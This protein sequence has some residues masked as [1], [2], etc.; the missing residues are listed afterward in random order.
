MFPGGKVPHHTELKKEGGF[1]HML[2]PFEVGGSHG[3]VGVPPRVD[4][5][6][7]FA[8]WRDFVVEDSTFGVAT[9]TKKRRRQLEGEGGINPDTNNKE[10]AITGEMY[11]FGYRNGTHPNGMKNQTL[12]IQFQNFNLDEI[13]ACSTGPCTVELNDNTNNC[14]DSNSDT[15][16]TRV[17]LH[18]DIANAVSEIG[19]IDVGRNVEELFDLPISIHDN[20]GTV[21]ACAIFTEIEDVSSD[22]AAV[23]SPSDAMGSTVGLSALFVLVSSL[24]TYL[25]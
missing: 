15:E 7:N 4:G 3:P 16:E 8:Q 1:V 23:D 5:G 13:E 9:F 25:F 2:G 11:I 24:V 21:L 6:G 17:I 14:D 19:Y 20:N 12:E 10:G 18:E 22:T